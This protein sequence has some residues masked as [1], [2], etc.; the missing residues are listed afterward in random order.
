MSEYDSLIA[1]RRYVLW[2]CGLSFLFYVNSIVSKEIF[3]CTG[4]DGSL[5]FTDTACP[6]NTG[7]SVEIIDMPETTPQGYD[8]T[9]DYYSIE[10]QARRMKEER[11]EREAI[12]ADLI[13]KRQ[14]IQRLHEAESLREEAQRL[15]DK[16]SRI[17]PG[18]VGRSPK[19]LKAQAQ[20][21][22]RK[23]KMLEKEAD[24]VSGTN[25]TDRP[26]DIERFED[27]Q[28]QIDRKNVENKFK[29]KHLRIEEIVKRSSVENEVRIQK[30]RFE[31]GLTSQKNLEKAVNDCR[32]TSGAICQ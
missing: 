11:L 26:D 21:L 13:S 30:R 19:E 31:L 28:D 2:I 9:T 5:Y 4:E 10:N 22:E 20:T 16:A 32:M 3:K 12:R 24:I 23:A 29:D 25:N 6:V 17:N 27:E 8:P 18:E 7:G 1:P 15:K 14:A